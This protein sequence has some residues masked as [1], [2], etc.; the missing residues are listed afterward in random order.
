MQ[1]GNTPLHIAAAIS[2]EERM[3]I[4]L[5]QGAD[6]NKKNNVSNFHINNFVVF[7]M[8]YRVGIHLFI[9]PRERRITNV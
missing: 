4:L 9:W 8:V 3:K 1:D 6:V 5:S 7:I 2:Y